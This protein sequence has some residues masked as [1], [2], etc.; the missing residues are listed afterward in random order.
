MSA[1]GD[2]PAGFGFASVVAR[3]GSTPSPV[4]SSTRARRSDTRRFKIISLHC[5][6]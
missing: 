1:A 6:H 4:R 3:A 5:T 2:V